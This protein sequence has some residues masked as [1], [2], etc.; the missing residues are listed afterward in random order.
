LKACAKLSNP[1]NA[2]ARSPK[3]TKSRNTTRFK[4]SQRHALSGFLLAGR[5]VFLFAGHHETE[6]CRSIHR[7]AGHFVERNAFQAKRSGRA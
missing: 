1:A 2:V 5:R 3:P 4:L 6:I 7:F